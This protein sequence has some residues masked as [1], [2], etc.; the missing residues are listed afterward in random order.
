MEV[1]NLRGTER[2][3]IS[4]AVTGSYGAASITI[5]DVSAQGAQIAHAQP[6]RLGGKAR[7]TF[8]IGSLTV[9]AQGLTIWSRFAKSA[10]TRSNMVYRSGIRIE[11]DIEEFANAVRSLIDRGLAQPDPESLDRKRQRLLDRH[12][13]KTS[14]LV[15]KGLKPP[16]AEIPSDQ[17]LLIQHARERLRANPEEA[18]KWYNRARYVSGPQISDAIPNREEVLAVW[19][20]L[21]RSVDVPTIVTVFERSRKS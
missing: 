10:E 13:E 6:L 8:K 21:E 11:S 17:V 19:E 14:K 4:E 12:A 18:L 16:E 9:T 3:I 7:L 2:Y 1:Q 15:V 20:Y 5:V